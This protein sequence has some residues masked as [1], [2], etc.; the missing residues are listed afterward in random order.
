MSASSFPASRLAARASESGH[1]REAGICLAGGPHLVPAAPCDRR[2][3]G[4]SLVL[5]WAGHGR[6]AGLS[7]CETVGSRCW[8]LTYTPCLVLAAVV[9]LVELTSSFVAVLVQPA[10]HALLLVLVQP[11]GWGGRVACGGVPMESG[12]EGFQRA[13]SGAA[14]AGGRSA[15]CQGRGSSRS[16]SRSGADGGGRVCSSDRRWW[17]AHG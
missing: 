7:T 11:A 5:A 13:S 6:W 17:A 9:I 16:I 8:S 1:W 12:G 10:I 2:R 14:L 3:T 15:G 4:P